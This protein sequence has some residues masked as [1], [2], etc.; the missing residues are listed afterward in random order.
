MSGVRLRRAVLGAA[1]AAIT[2]GCTDTSNNA[3]VDA[4][5]AGG[6][7]AGAMVASEPGYLW[8]AGSGLQAFQ[9]SET[10]TSNDDG[11]ALV[12]FPDH[13]ASRFRDLAFDH[14][15]NVWTIPLSG[16]QI[17]RIPA[18][19][20]ANAAKPR[21]DLVAQSPALVG[22]Q[23]LAFDPAGNLWVLSASGTDTAVAS[24]VRFDG[25][26][27]QVGNATLVPA[28]IIKPGADADS[29]N[30]FRQATAIALDAAGNLWMAAISGVLRFD[31]P[32]A[33]QGMVSPTPSATRTCRSR[34]TRPA[35]CGSPAPPPAT[36]R[37]ASQTPARSPGPSCR[38]PPPRCTC[39][40]TACCSRAAWASTP[41]AR[42]G[43][44]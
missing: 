28:A 17:V 30:R 39:R 1:L 38:W 4:N 7:D 42:C 27:T 40:P 5:G 44:R 24:I 29:V 8:L 20:L 12:V 36:S 6:S 21:P 26:R 35:R 14:D 41:T 15:G 9:R 19:Q 32:G 13:P 34:S 33:L 11:P 18:A 10:E 2:C 37:C 16:D 43:W 3:P 23:S 31:G 22:A 25:A